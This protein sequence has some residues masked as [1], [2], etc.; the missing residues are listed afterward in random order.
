[1]QKEEDLRMNSI[2][3]RRSIRHYTSE[4][5]TDL[6]LKEILRAAMSAPSA[7]NQRPWHFIVV[8]DKTR[9]SHLSETHKYSDMVKNAPV[10]V[11]VCG[12]IHLQSYK[13]YWALDC[14][15]AAEN[16]LIEAEELG[17]GAV[18]VAV[19]PRDERI[20][21]VRTVLSLPPNILPLCII[22]IGHPAEKPNHVER[23]DQSRIHAERW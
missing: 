5:I 16:I 13:D 19:Y 14:S 1:L 21:H 15:A 23:Y 22:P 18:W 10:A 6:Q 9:L 17:L 3:N 8:K 2:F 7:R 20:D 4:D 11:V 12:D